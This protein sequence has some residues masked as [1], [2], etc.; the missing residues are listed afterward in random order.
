MAVYD[1]SGGAEV[2]ASIKGMPLTGIGLA[3][4]V[5]EVLDG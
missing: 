5:R 2:V 3:T 1:E 4:R